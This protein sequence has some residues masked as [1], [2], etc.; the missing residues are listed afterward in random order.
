MLEVWEYLSLTG[1]GNGG[2]PPYGGA[3]LI[4]AGHP[5]GTNSGAFTDSLWFIPD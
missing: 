3:W 5:L 4:C 1:G 2:G